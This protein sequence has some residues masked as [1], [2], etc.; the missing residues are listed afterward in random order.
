[1]S[2]RLFILFVCI[3]DMLSGCEKARQIVTPQ[4]GTAPGICT[5]RNPR[6]D[7]SA[8]MPISRR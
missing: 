8:F 2:F 1:M 3:T 6:V 4:K 5:G 7:R